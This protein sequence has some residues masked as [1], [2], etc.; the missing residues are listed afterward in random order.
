MKFKT[1]LIVLTLFAFLTSCKESVKEEKF[2]GYVIS[3]IVKGI[4]NVY[5]KLTNT[6]SRG[7]KDFKVI[8]S[9]QITNG[10]F[11]FKGKVDNVDMVSIVIDSKYHGMFM[12]ENSAINVSID[13]SELNERNAYF[14]PVVSGS[15]SHDI[16]A[17]V[18][19]KSSAIFEL[20]KYKIIDELK[21]LFAKANK[22][23]DQKDMDIATIRQKELMPLIE[24]A[25]N[26][27]KQIKYDF[28]KANPTSPVAVHVLGYQYTE[29]RM[30]KEQLKEF[31]HLF[32]G[33]ATKT[34]F[35]KYHMTKVYKDNFENMGV[36]NTVPDFTLNSV[37][38]KALTL[39]KIEGKYLL[40]DFWASWCVP[41]RASFPHLKELRKE[42]KKDGFTIVGIGTAD[43][44][45]KWR[46]A[47]IKDQTPWIHLYDS[48]ENHAYGA[49]AK[50]YGVPHLPTTFLID[51]NQK[52]ILRNPTKEKL[53][54]KLKELFGH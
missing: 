30:T 15:K 2:D 9:V 12:L 20:E 23:N 24:E 51:S 46:K 10:K 5:L 45:G 44:E 43:E 1:V 35:Y 50:K 21:D 47:I 19:K 54:A 26:A 4:D 11:S 25:N 28:A 48:S 38:N 7:S 14:T 3:G 6:G 40:V 16:Y 18:E 29:G 42:Y 37:N 8:D 31:Y 17:A 34:G 41:C 52:I 27:Y 39:S 49:V 13:V 22:T 53:D 32:K 36:G 33:D